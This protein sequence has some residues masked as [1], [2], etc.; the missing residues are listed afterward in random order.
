MRQL[1]GLACAGTI[2]LGGG[3]IALADGHHDGQPT[4]TA[5]ATQLAP[6]P[7]PRIV[8]A[9]TPTSP[10]P[11]PTPTPPAASP[12]SAS[13]PPPSEVTPVSG[14]PIANV[15]PLHVD[16]AGSQLLNA[17]YSSA[18]DLYPCP[19]G[20]SYSPPSLNASGDLDL[21]TS[22]QAGSCAYLQSNAQYGYGAY[23]ARVYVPAGP[24]GTIANWPAFY[25]SGD[26]WPNGGEI[27]AFEAMG[28]TDFAGYDPS[29]PAAHLSGPAITSTPGW[30][31]VDA[32]WG[33]GTLT[34]YTDGQLADQ[35]SS[36]DLDI[37]SGGTSSMLWTFDNFT[38]QYGYNTGQPSTMQVQ[39]FRYW[40]WQ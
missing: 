17:W 30:H 20:S 24:N 32:V 4:P 38:G 12:P 10:S 35:W 25:G 26:N 9:S 1:L 36:P 34:I 22:G 40:T 6:V 13:H 18:S 16:L 39:Y 5:T 8:R 23:E 28:G 19:G 29:L 15:G 2:A 7:K 31:I 14:V 27:D 21:T 3:S 37:T 11:A 33:P